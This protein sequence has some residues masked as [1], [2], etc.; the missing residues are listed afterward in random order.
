MTHQL[1]HNDCTITRSVLARIYILLNAFKNKISIDDSLLEN[2]RDIKETESQN[3]CFP[4]IFYNEVENKINAAN[5]IIDDFERY[6]NEDFLAKINGTYEEP[7]ISLN[8]PPIN[9]ENY[10]CLNGKKYKLVEAEE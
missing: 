9:A 8:L 4:V 2:I 1:K 5:C 3:E 7:V 10:I 6:Y